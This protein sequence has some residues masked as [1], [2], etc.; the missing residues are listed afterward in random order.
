MKPWLEDRRFGESRF[1]FL[2]AAYPFVREAAILTALYPHVYVDVSLA[3]PLSAHGADDV[4]LN[5]LEQ[6]PTTKLLYGS[7]ASNTPELFGWAAYVA[8]R[9][10]IDCLT[11]L[12]TNDW[13]MPLE[14]SEITRQLF[15]ENA[16]RLSR[17][18]R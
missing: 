17:C 16:R 3:I 14:A 1:V 18:S 8:K 11:K 6:A 15:R 13:L 2:H 12:L 4:F 9:S 5:L 10:W 7:D